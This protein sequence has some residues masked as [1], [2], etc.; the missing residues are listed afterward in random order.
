MGGK[1][2]KS[3]YTIVIV[4]PTSQT[5]KWETS[6]DGGK[7]WKTGRRGQVDEKVTAKRSSEGGDARGIPY[8]IEEGGLAAALCR[9]GSR[10]PP[11]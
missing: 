2:I 6:E 10:I 4:S 8:S 1:L 11:P 5:F 7:T 3:K 9:L